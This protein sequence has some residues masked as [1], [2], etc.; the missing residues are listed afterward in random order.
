MIAA[1]PVHAIRTKLCVDAPELWQGNQNGG[2]V[3]RSPVL[4]SGER[5]L[6]LKLDFIN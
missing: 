4:P 3:H 6:L 2:L 5:R 1:D